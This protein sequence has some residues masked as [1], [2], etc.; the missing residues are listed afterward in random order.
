MDQTP[1]AQLKA[2]L[3]GLSRQQ[4]RALTRK[5]MLNQ[6]EELQL[7]QAMPRNVRRQWASEA[8]KELLRSL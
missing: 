7:A 2:K 6:L 5:G 3:S 1:Q 8:G 4:R